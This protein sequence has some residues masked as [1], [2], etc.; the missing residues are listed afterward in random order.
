M[1]PAA[2]IILQLLATLSGIVF[3]VVLI[4]TVIECAVGQPPLIIRAIGQ[5][6]TRCGRGS[7]K[8]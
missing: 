5:A 2:A 7:V 1:P 6:F 4:V 3:L 8:R